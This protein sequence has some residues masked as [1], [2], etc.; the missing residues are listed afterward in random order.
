MITKRTVD[1]FGIVSVSVV[2][3]LLIAMV[4]HLVPQN[5]SLPLALIAMALFLL[6]ITMRLTYAYQQRKAKEGVKEPPPEA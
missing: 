3:A 4:L 6:R 2:L 5:Y 1:I